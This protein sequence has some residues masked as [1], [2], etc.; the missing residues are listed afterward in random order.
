MTPIDDPR[1]SRLSGR[2]PLPLV[3]L[4]LIENLHRL[5]QRMTLAWQTPLR[6]PSLSGAERTQK[7]SFLSAARRPRLSILTLRM[8]RNRRTT[9]MKGVGRALNVRVRIRSWLVMRLEQARARLARS[10]SGR[11]GL[12]K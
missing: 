1:T 5:I 10:F 3:S 7:V 2:R 6:L 4:A 8:D 12:P 9:V 11:L